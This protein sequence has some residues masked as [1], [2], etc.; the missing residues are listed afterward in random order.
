LLCKSAPLHDI[1]KVAVRDGILLKPAPL[2]EPEMAEMKRH[3]LYGRDA[4]MACE[5]RLGTESFLRLAREIAYTHHERWDGTGYPQGLKAE[6]IPICG[7]LMALADVYDALISKRVYKAPVPHTQAV[8]TIAEGRA[9]HF[10]P[11]LVAAFLELR[12]EFRSVA[13]RFADHDEERR[14]IAS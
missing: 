5:E 14:A 10:D 8:T 9:M 12:E 1:G 6:Q 2:T 4:I 11:D 13:L 7:R 3:T